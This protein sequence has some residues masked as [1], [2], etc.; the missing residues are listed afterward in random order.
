MKGIRLNRHVLM[1]SPTSVLL[2]T[3]LLLHG[4]VREPVK[5][6]LRALGEMHWTLLL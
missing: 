1:T 5:A 3:V 6:R 4:S 2:A